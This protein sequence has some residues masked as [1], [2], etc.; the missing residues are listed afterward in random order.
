VLCA[1][2]QHQ[3]PIHVIGNRKLPAPPIVVGGSSE[4]S[5]SDGNICLTV[6]G[7]PPIV[8][9]FDPIFQIANV[10]IVPEESLGVQTGESS[11]GNTSD[12]FIWNAEYEFTINGNPYTINL[13]I[14]GRTMMFQ[15]GGKSFKLAD[16]NYFR[17]KLLSGPS[18]SV[19]QLP[20]IDVEDDDTAKVK[21]IFKNYP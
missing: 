1:C 9:A 16:G 20:V 2:T 19:Q 17:I 3:S 21:S 18:L 11:N 14:D 15:A 8:K 5:N 13:S 4:D 10:I 7:E 6:S 12:K